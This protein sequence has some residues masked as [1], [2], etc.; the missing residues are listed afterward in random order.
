[1]DRAA[2]K[3]ANF[4]VALAASV[5][6]LSFWGLLN[7]AYE[8]PDWPARVMGFSFSPTLADQDPLAGRLPSRDDIDADLALLAGTTHALRTYTVRDAMAEVP[9]LARKHGM[10]TY[11]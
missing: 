1:M 10:T 2:M 5:L 8:A 11:L 7:P 9:A 6:T 3:K 4:A